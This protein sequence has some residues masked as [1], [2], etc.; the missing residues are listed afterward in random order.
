MSEKRKYIRRK[1]RKQATTQGHINPNK[2][3]FKP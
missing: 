1:Q 2:N 3:P